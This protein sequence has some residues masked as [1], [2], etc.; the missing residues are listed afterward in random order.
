LAPWAREQVYFPLL[1]EWHEMTPPGLWEEYK[2]LFFFVDGTVIQIWKPKDSKT[3][4]CCFSSKH[5]KTA[6]Q[7]FVLVTPNGHISFVSHVKGGATHDKTHWNESGAPSQLEEKY[8]YLHHTK[9]AI[10]GDK[11]YP[12]LK[13]P[14]NFEC[15]VTMT[16]DSLEESGV[17]FMTSS[18]TSN[19]S[20]YKHCPKIAKYR[21][22]VERTFAALK[23]W[24]CLA[25]VSFMSRIKLDEL[26]LLLLVLSALTNFQLKK[27]QKW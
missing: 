15:Y 7:F 20:P 26:E 6:W 14:S 3:N 8:G 11:A 9:M 22:V 4:Q 16:A 25:S 19:L 5:N 10:G 12:D 21:A 18:S 24:H 2:T 23:Q 1:S 17:S 27:H 13:R